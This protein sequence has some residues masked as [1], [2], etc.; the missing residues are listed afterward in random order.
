MEERKLNLKRIGHTISP[1]NGNTV[2]LTELKDFEKD[3]KDLK[4]IF[5]CM[6]GK[7]SVIGYSLFEWMNGT[8]KGQIDGQIITN[9]PW[10]IYKNLVD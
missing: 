1:E 7:Y 3:L 10:D 6:G 9:L 5:N 2:F 8:C 4:E